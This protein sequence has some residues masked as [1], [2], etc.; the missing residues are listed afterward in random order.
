MLAELHSKAVDY[1]KTGEPAKMPKRFKRRSF[2]HFMEKLHCQSYHSDQVLGKL[3]DRVKVEDFHPAYQMPFDERI[4]RKYKLDNE[5]L[6]KARR[7]KSQYDIAMKRLIAQKEIATEFEVWTTFVLSKPRVGGQYKVQEDVGREALALKM[8]FREQCIET[9]GSRDFHVLGPF[10]AA[11]YQVTSEEV[12]IALHESR[13][14]QMSSDGQVYIKR[15]D[16][17]SMPLIS[18]PWLFDRELGQIATGSAANPRSIG[19]R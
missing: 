17:K 12:K 16:A 10:V 9:A 11:M 8:R 2:P 18:F 6:K 3:Y 4:L 13:T 5:T 14:R 19:F 1:V 7:I 15:V